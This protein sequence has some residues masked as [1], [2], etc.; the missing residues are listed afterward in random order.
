MPEEHYVLKDL[1]FYK[2]AREA[3]A[4]TRQE[5]LNQMEEKRQNRKLRR[6]PGKKG[7]ASSSVACPSAKKKKSSAKAVKVSTPVLVLLSTSTPSAYTSAD[8]SVLDSECDLG[9]PDFKQNDSGHRHSETR[10][11]S[12]WRHK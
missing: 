1:I 12:T 7:Q 10:P 4:K 8:S 11:Y 2:E 9:L 5:H 6:A 3:N